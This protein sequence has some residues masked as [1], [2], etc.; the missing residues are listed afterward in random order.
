MMLD[1]NERPM[2]PVHVC[3]NDSEGEIIASVLRDGGIKSVLNSEVPHSILPIQTGG[4]GKVA[5]YVDEDN[6]ERA[7]EVIAQH[8]EKQN[9]TNDDSPKE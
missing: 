3:W 4:L 7:K 5:V 9:Q 1:E 2:V 8:L 6:A